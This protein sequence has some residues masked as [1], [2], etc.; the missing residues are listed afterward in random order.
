M[1]FICRF[2]NWDAILVCLYRKLYFLI[3]E[4]IFL[5]FLT[6]QRQSIDRHFSWSIV[7]K[8]RW[9]NVLFQ[10]KGLVFLALSFLYDINDR[11]DL[12]IAQIFRYPFLVEDLDW[13]LKSRHFEWNNLLRSSISQKNQ[14]IK[15]G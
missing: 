12:S 10:R 6:N 15:I 2:T 11:R 5:F 7:S 14:K 3:M 13:I 4:S 1:S 9:N 8:N